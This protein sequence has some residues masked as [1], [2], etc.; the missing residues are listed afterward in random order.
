MMH[1][2]LPSP[3]FLEQEQWRVFR[4]RRN[5]FNGESSSA[6]S[7][8][9]VPGSLLTS[10]GGYGAGLAV[11]F[12]ITLFYRSEM[13]VNTT[14]VGLA[15]LRTLVKRKKIEAQPAKPEFLLTHPWVGYQLLVNK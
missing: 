13:P 9:I 14:T 8:F 7:K 4:S 3:T 2:S 1:V 6:V 10:I 15:L 12:L 11:I 5:P